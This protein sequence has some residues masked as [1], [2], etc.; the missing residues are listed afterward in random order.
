M[1][2]GRLIAALWWHPEDAG[3]AFG[4]DGKMMI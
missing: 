3:T 4:V 2:S 1:A